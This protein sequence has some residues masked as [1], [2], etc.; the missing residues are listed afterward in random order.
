MADKTIKVKVDVETDVEPTIA[1][2][3][4]LKKQLKDTAAGSAEFLALQKQIDDVQDSLKSARVGAGNFADVISQL[5]GPVGQLGGQASGLIATL[6][7]FGQLKLTDIKSSFVELGKDL[8]DA[9]VGL[10]RLTG[11]TKV[12]TVLNNA[13]AKSFVAVGVGE[14]VAAAGARAFAAA[15]VATGIGA[16]IIYLKML[17]YFLH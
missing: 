6:K 13:L 15:L 17:N 16:L 9:A 14:G 3:K 4:A 10:G 2:L 7:Q 8:V 11:I 1:A 5:P 12:Y